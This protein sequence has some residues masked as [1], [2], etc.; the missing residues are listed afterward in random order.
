MLKEKVKGL[1]EPHRDPERQKDGHS[2]AGSYH[3]ESSET[4]YFMNLGLEMPPLEPLPSQY[5][6]PSP[7]KLNPPPSKVMS[8]PE[9]VK[10][11]PAQPP[12]VRAPVSAGST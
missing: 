7:S 8:D 12:A 3:R 6:L 9:M 4:A 10:S 1:D 11:G 2:V 5:L